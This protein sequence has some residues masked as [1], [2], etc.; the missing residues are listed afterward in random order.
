MKIF[1]FGF[2]QFLNCFQSLIN[3]QF[4]LL[5]VLQLFQSSLNFKFNF[6]LLFDTFSDENLFPSLFMI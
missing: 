5:E 3:F 6:H 2:H 1:C 4:L